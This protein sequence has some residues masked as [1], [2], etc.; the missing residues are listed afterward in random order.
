MNTSRFRLPGLK[1]KI[2]T[3]ALSIEPKTGPGTGEKSGKIATYPGASQIL[4][5]STRMS[6]TYN[7][8]S[9][10]CKHFMANSVISGEEGAVCAKIDGI[11]M[12]IRRLTG[13][14]VK[15]PIVA[16][17]SKMVTRRTK[18]PFGPPK[19]DRHDKRSLKLGRSR[20]V[21]VFKN[22]LLYTSP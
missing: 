12:G 20:T 21:I 18:L 17:R 6:H 11:S 10:Y 1:K 13:H 19:S 15:T 9:E 4:F 7:M 2:S 8:A 16:Y 3:R 22:C 5:L 14:A